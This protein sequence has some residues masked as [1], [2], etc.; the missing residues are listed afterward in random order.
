MSDREKDAINS[1]AQGI[2]L[3]KARR[4]FLSIGSIVFFN[5]IN[6]I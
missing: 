2:E 6:L 3:N 1:Q 5:K 4:I